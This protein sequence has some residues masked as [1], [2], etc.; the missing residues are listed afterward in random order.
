MKVKDLL[1][2]ENNFAVYLG[3]F[4]LGTWIGEDERFYTSRLWKNSILN[5]EVILI[6]FNYEIGEFNVDWIKIG[7][8]NNEIQKYL[9]NH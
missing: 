4:K 8:N 7:I 9:L 1:C 6:E 5:S 2:I 3:N